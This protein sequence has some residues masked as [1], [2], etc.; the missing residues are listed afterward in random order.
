MAVD[1]LAEQAVIGSLLIDPEI[2][3]ELLTVSVPEDFALPADRAVF[4]AARR[5]YRAGR[6]V[7][8]FTLRDRLGDEY[9]A[10][11]AQLMDVTPT[12]ANWREY[13]AAAHGQALMDRAKGLAGRL[14]EA[15]TLEECRPLC[16][17]LGQLLSD[18]RQLSTWTV[19]EMF[20]SFC[21]SQDPER[22]AAEYVSFGLPVLDEGLYV[23]RG[24]V[25]MLGG[26][27]SD[28]K[29]ALAL[30][31]A[32]H[33]AGKYR[34]GFFSLETARRKLRDRLVAHAMGISFSA[35][36]HRSVSEEDWGKLSHESE[37]W[38]RRDL[39]VVEATGMTVS[40]IAAASRAYAFDVV[41]IDYVQLIKSETGSRAPRSEQ[42]AAVSQT[43][44][45]FAQQT[46]TLV[47]ELAQLVRPERTK[48]GEPT[49]QDIK[50]SGQF[51]QDADVVLLIFRPVSDDGLD[52]E[53]HRIL[54]VGK[55]K[56]GRWGRWPLAFDG[57]RQ[58]FSLLTGEAVRKDMVAAGRRAKR[59]PREDADQIGIHEIEETADMPF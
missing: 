22:P 57:D 46:G 3:P 37:D 45:T 59:R 25:V 28:G 6:P 19:P 32:W 42:M 36:K 53:L 40:D 35:I 51:E 12:S 38:E 50:E 39:T 30:Q 14:A 18:G 56:E 16:A 23:E 13:A 31:M 54:K 33:M 58:T 1:F 5:L 29:T 11:M 43:L 44:H 15:G 17:E 26:Y 52:S 8:P 2:L 4:E 7:D 41:L 20:Q 9:S 48:R 24:D 47:V 27:P 10:Y 55:N 34:V 21:E 49:M